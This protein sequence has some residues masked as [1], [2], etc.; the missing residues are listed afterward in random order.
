MSTWRRR[1]LAGMAAIGQIAVLARLAAEDDP[2]DP[3][4]AHELSSRLVRCPGAVRLSLLQGAVGVNL[5][6]VLPRRV[7]EQRV[8]ASR[9]RAPPGAALVRREGVFELL[10]ASQGNYRELVYQQRVVRNDC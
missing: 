3:A 6:R 9:R 2:H 4:E 1:G 8:E 10:G 5:L 7:I